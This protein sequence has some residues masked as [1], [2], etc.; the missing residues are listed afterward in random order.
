MTDVYIIGVGMT[1]FGKHM[2]RSIKDLTREAVTDALADAG[3]EKEQLQAAWFA[4]STW[5][6]FSGQDQ[7]R[8]QVALGAMGIYAIPIMNVEAACG[9]GSQ[10]MHGAWLAV[11]SGAYDCVLAV[12][13]EKLY[14]PEKT[15]SFQALSTG[16]DVER[17]PEMNEAWRR[18]FEQ[19][20]LLKETDMADDGPKK[21]GP[22]MEMYA[23]MV[24]DHM[25]TFG[26]TQRQL[27]II[28]AKDHYHGSL[29]P[30]AQYQKAMTADEVLAGKPI[31]YPLTAPMCAPLGDGSAAAIICS[32][33]YLKAVGN[34]RAVKILASVYGSNTPRPFDDRENTIAQRL[35]RSAFD[36]AGIGPDD[37]DLIEIHD[38]ASFAEV[39]IPEQLGFCSPGE[40]GRFAESGATTLGGRLPVNV[41]GGLVSRGHPLGATGVAQIHELVTQLRGEAGARQVQNARIGMSENGG[42]QIHFEE[43]S[44]GIHILVGVND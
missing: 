35:S 23:L 22:M 10:A 7:I 12:G 28:A 13:S 4:N 18:R 32:A 3:I 6:F 29:N 14:H 25:N 9:G 34:Q 20:G 39:A 11:R 36:M 19:L 43:A 30:K 42:G 27:A 2:D 33:K 40:G 41:S 5:G 44:M 8:G 16:T 26:L 15:R 31:V 21:F 1:H 24:R 37:V 38:A 17:I